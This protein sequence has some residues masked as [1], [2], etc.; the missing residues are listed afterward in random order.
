MSPSMPGSSSS[1]NRS[2][3]SSATIESIALICAVRAGTNRFVIDMCS[4]S[5]RI[6]AHVSL[7]MGLIQI[8]HG[9]AAFSALLG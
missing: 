1:V 5:Q 4:E 6:L 8:T 9:F 2:S 7:C 3:T